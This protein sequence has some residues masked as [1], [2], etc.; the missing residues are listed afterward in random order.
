[1]THTLI[2]FLGKT[3]KGG[4][5]QEACYQF[6]DGRQETTRFFSLALEKHI[7][8]QQMVILGTSGSMWDVLCENLGADNH[9]HWVVLSEAAENDCVTQAQLQQFDEVVSQ[10]LGVTCHLKLI[11]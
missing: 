4:Q 1:M 9:E 10:T 2:S 7:K 5:Y 3:Q 6:T 11:P 8:P